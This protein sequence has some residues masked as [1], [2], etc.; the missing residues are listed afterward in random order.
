MRPDTRCTR[1]NIGTAIDGI[2]VYRSWQRTI[3]VRPARRHQTENEKIGYSFPLDLLLQAR[4]EILKVLLVAKTKS[5]MYLVLLYDVTVRGAAVRGDR[6]TWTISE[7]ATSRVRYTVRR[8]D[9]LGRP[10]GACD[11]R[12]PRYALGV[13]NATWTRYIPN[14]LYTL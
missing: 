2:N 3:E 9:H 1:N 13:S 7:S 8:T 5:V 6:T 12:Q 4:L 14:L 10:P 11:R